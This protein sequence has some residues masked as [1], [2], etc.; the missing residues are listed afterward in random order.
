MFFGLLY[1]DFVSNS[2]VKFDEWIDFLWVIGWLLL[3]SAIDIVVHAN[4]QQGIEDW[5]GTETLA[6]KPK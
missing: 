5:T 6:K 1:V 4:V 3:R 2:S